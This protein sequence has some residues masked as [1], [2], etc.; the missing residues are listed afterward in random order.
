MDSQGIS[1][2]EHGFVPGPQNATL[3]A[4]PQSSGSVLA[5]PS[6]ANDT[7][8]IEAEWIDAAK[9][10]I[11]ANKNDPSNQNQAI[12]QLRRAYLKQRYGRDIGTPK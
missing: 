8:V 6:V 5:S 2:T 4:Q 12:G 11:V 10:A 3:P 7:D 1:G 9:Q